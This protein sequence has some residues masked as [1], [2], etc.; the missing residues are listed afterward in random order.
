MIL[1]RLSPPHDYPPF[2]D[3]PVQ[4][5]TV[6]AASRQLAVHVSGHFTV[7]QPPIVCV[8]GFIR[9]M[10]DFGD[11][12]RHYRQIASVDW[13]FVLVD[14]SGRGRS[15]RHDHADNYSALSDAHDLS[16]I[17]RALGISRAIFVGQGHGGQVIMA[18]AAQHPAL[19]AAAVLI[20]SGPTTNPRGLV[21]LR[22]NLRY[23][24]GVRGNDQIRAAARRIL[25]TDY[26]GLPEAT[27]DQLATRTHFIDTK[28]R[29]HGIFD[30][31]LVQFLDAFE[32]DDV[33]EPQW[34]LFNALAHIPLMLARTQ[35]TDRLDNETFDQMIARRPDATVVRLAGE[36]S[37]AL[38]NSED[39]VAVI[40]DFV[41]QA[42][43]S[44]RRW[45]RY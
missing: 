26:P 7:D 17:T 39:E 30:P 8:P 35:L 23:L 10:S 42:G 15:G 13:P 34:H 40:A 25:I 4:Y 29:L 37:P 33:F 18:L 41:A 20:N 3:L 38:L 19:L 45:A 43:K 2:A 9:N 32:H 21:R 22:S 28:E 36:G 16:T 6:G 27:L 24:E 14:L 1:K 5:I 44:P 12:M 31:D 11:F